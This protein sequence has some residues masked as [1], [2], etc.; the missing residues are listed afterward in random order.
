L[1]TKAVVG[2]RSSR[3]LGN[4]GQLLDEQSMCADLLMGDVWV[5]NV[6]D[7]TFGGFCGHKW[8]VPSLARDIVECGLLTWGMV[9]QIK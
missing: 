5:D 7:D 8:K 3:I 4:R 9:E 1:E 2:S 6:F